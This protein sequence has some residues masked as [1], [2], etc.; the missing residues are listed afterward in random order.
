M[1]VQVRDNN[2]DQALRVLKKRLQRANAIGARNAV[3]IGD[4]EVE[5]GAAQLK[6]L[7][8]GE[9]RAVPFGE[10]VGALRR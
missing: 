9:Q 6:D 10:I 1:Q 4:S 7:G 3:I 2:V 5:A 8:S